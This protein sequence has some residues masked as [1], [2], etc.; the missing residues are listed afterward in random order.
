MPN[1]CWKSD[2]CA[3]RQPQCLEAWGL[4]HVGYLGTVAQALIY[5]PTLTG[6]FYWVSPR[7]RENFGPRIQ[8]RY[9]G[10]YCKTERTSPCTITHEPQPKM[11][12]AFTKE[13]EAKAFA[14]VVFSAWNARG[15]LLMIHH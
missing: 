10:R 12:S 15:L 6:D 14:A 2:W 13:Q 7:S 9:R 4:F 3:Q 11:R 1:A 5:S 8:R